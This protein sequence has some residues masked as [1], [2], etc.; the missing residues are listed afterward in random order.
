MPITRGGTPPAASPRIL[1]FGV[2]P[3]AFA[4][5]SDAIINAQEPSLMPDELPAVTEPPSRNA[6]RSFCKPSIVEPGLNVHPYQK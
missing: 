2:S 5:S 4:V 1:A 3:F 6:G